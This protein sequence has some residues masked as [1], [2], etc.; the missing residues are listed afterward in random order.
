MTHLFRLRIEIT[1][2]KIRFYLIV[3]ELFKLYIGILMVMFVYYSNRNICATYASSEVG[4]FTSS[5]NNI[6]M[7]F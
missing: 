5:V 2:C 6:N 7:Y 3:Y 1:I 4:I